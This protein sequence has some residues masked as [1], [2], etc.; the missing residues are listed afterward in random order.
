[1]FCGECGTSLPAN[2]VFCGSCGFD[3]SNLPSTSNIVAAQ[4]PN[5]YAGVETIKAKA[6][7]PG[8]ANITK[9]YTMLAILSGFLLKIPFLIGALLWSIALIG[10]ITFMMYEMTKYLGISMS[11]DQV[12][13]VAVTI[14]T[15]VAA[16]KIIIILI[17]VIISFIPIL[18]IAAFV[19]NCVIAGTMVNLAAKIYKNLVIP[20]FDSNTDITKLSKQELNAMAKNASS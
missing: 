7:E 4:A 18:G 14:A 1:M 15:V 8:F 5:G 20:L 16:K 13:R 9:K 6:A 10:V 11:K 3:M 17:K 2:A 12:K 19:I